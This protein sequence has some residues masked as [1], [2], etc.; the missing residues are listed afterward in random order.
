[1]LN[2]DISII[3]SSPL[4]VINGGHYKHKMSSHIKEGWYDSVVQ[5]TV[6]DSMWAES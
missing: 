1:M 2:P 4:Q 6:K 3:T 5:R